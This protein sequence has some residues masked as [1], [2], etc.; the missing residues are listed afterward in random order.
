MRVRPGGNAVVGAT[1]MR[2]MGEA[3]TERQA[4]IALHCGSNYLFFQRGLRFSEN[5]A[6]PS[7]P[8][9]LW[10]LFTIAAVASR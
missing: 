1:G 6:I 2:R 10:T 5:A 3:Q 7:F 9:S 8:S 4:G